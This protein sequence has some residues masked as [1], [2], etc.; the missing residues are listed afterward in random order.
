MFH[1]SIPSEHAFTLLPDKAQEQQIPYHFSARKTRRGT[2]HLSQC[3]LVLGKGAVAAGFN[4]RDDANPSRRPS[5]SAIPSFLADVFLRSGGRCF[6][7]I[8]R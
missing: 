6:T 1:E 5:R 3:L 2:P 4:F 8:D 7:R